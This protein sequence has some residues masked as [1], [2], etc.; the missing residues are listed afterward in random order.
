[1]TG[2]RF[3]RCSSCGYEWESRDGF[4]EDPALC[5]IGYQ[6]DFEHLKEGLFL[7]NHS[8]GTTLAIMAGDF[9]DLYEG[10][11]FSERLTGSGE[12]PEYCLHQSELRPCPAKC[13]CAYVREIV[14]IITDRP[15]RN[16]TGSASVREPR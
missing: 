1:M 7:F 11:V 16:P 13:E 12:C 14:Q 3:K 6:V 4:I 15:R 9:R 10:P 2:R 8:C 5:I